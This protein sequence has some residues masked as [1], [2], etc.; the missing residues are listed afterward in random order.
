MVERWCFLDVHESARALAGRTSLLTS[1]GD[2][3]PGQITRPQGRREHEHRYKRLA[4]AQR[5]RFHRGSC[6][7]ETIGGCAAESGKVAC[8]R[9]H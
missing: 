9:A 3:P 5:E 8:N 7:A 4:R 2:I 1:V 6:R